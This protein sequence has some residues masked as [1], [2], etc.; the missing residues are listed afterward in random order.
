MYRFMLCHFVYLPI[1]YAT[2]KISMWSKK[3]NPAKYSCNVILSNPL[4]FSRAV[5]IFIRYTNQLVL[6]EN[7]YSKAHTELVACLANIAYVLWARYCILQFSRGYLTTLQG[8]LCC[9]K[10]VLL[11]AT[12]VVFNTLLSRK[13]T[14][15]IQQTMLVLYASNLIAVMVLSCIKQSP[16][17]PPKYINVSINQL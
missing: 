14:Y 16:K 11:H 12:N 2:K 17:H 15:F 7:T 8:F 4:L 9:I 1:K 5:N 10:S 13:T 6:N 3:P